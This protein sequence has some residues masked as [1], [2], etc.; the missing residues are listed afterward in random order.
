MNL[1]NIVRS[2]ITSVNADQDM[3]YY[4]SLGTFS[5]DYSTMQTVPD[6]AAGVTV[7]AQVQS[8]K[9][10][11]VIHAERIEYGSVVRRIYLFATDTPAQRQTAL[12][13]PLAR[14]GDYLTD[15]FGQ[16]WKIDAVLEDFSSEGW[17]SVQAIMQQVPVLL[18][19]DD[20]N[21]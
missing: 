2:P 17:I 20:G 14:A 10:D 21:D 19:V 12:T 9:P 18:G 4:R 8:I 15:R 3:T 13:R 6:V 5:R 7:K 16:Q 1:H 11:D